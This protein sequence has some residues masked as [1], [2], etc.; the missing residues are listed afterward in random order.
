[1]ELHTFT[2]ALYG[3]VIV[4]F[5]SV[6]CLTTPLFF[7]SVNTSLHDSTARYLGPF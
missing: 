1:M 2:T 6:L 5:V 7:L 3:V 4:I